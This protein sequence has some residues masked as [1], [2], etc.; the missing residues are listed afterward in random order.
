MRLERLAPPVP[1]QQLAEY[2]SRFARGR[3]ASPGGGFLAAARREEGNFKFENS[4][5]K[6]GG[7][8]NSGE[9]GLKGG[10]EEAQGQDLDL[11]WE[12]NG[13]REGVRTIAAAEQAVNREEEISQPLFS[14]LNSKA[15]SSAT[16][17]AT[18]NAKALLGS[19]ANAN[20]DSGVGAMENA[21][22]NENSR[23]DVN[24]RRE[25]NSR[26]DGVRGNLGSGTAKSTGNGGTAG[27]EWRS[28]AQVAST[29][30]FRDKADRVA[31]ELRVGQGP[32]SCGPVR[33]KPE[34]LERIR[35]RNAGRDGL[36]SP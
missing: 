33:V 25:V 20:P 17:N 31:R 35:L 30:A 19:N 36:R 24:S 12:R 26:A 1:K 13:R 16:A 21:R 4:D 2:V 28:A 18:S 27:T 23:P 11:D 22:G 3:A 5:L 6:N 29:V 32:S 34:A 10:V 9:S 14:G 15:T 8:K 7:L